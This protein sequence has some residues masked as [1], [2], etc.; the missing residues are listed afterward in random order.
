V[1]HAAYDPF[2][3]NASILGTIT[4][5]RVLISTGRE[6]LYMDIDLNVYKLESI[7]PNNE[8]RQIL[9]RDSLFYFMAVGNPTGNQVYSFNH[10]QFTRLTGTT[11]EVMFSEDIFLYPNPAGEYLHVY[12][13]INP[14]VPAYEYM[15]F[16]AAG[17]RIE[18]GTIQKNDN[19]DI[20]MLPAGSYWIVC[21]MQGTYKAG[22]FVKM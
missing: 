2:N 15:I 21:N 11:E 20:R 3:L 14:D 10:E 1:L 4:N 12:D 19:L 16:N 13:T 7:T 9:L 22:R 8:Y 18:S 17:N 5:D 6:F